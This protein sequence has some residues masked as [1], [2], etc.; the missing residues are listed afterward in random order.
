[1]TL[2]A[3]FEQ[4]ADRIKCKDPKNLTESTDHLQDV[5]N[6]IFKDSVDNVEKIGNENDQP[7]DEVNESEEISEEAQLYKNI[8]DAD[9]KLDKRS[10][11]GKKL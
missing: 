4:M 9:G 1:M 7:A 8:V 11:I 5:F 10:A 6:N 2:A 3:Q